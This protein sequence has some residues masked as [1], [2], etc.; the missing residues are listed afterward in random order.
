MRYHAKKRITERNI[1]RD[2]SDKH[3]HHINEDNLNLTCIGNLSLNDVLAGTS[4]HSGTWSADLYVYHI[5]RYQSES[6]NG[7]L[8]PLPSCAPSTDDADTF[9]SHNCMRFHR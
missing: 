8:G 4:A 3:T 1:M 5:S 6:R 2:D 7:T 9:T